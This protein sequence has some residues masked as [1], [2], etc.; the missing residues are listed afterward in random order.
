M[1][2]SLISMI[3]SEYLFPLAMVA[4]AMFF[5][6]FFPKYWLVLTAVGWLGLVVIFTKISAPF[7]KLK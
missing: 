4:V 6:Y 5:G 1:F 2:K 7:D 3:L